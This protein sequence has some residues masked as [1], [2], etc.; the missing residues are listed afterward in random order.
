MTDSRGEYRYDATPVDT[1]L[2]RKTLDLGAQGPLPCPCPP[3]MRAIFCSPCVSQTGPCWRSSPTRWLAT[4]LAQPSALST[5]S[6][7]KGDLR[8]KLDKQQYAP[9]DTIKMRISTPYAGAGL[10][11]IEREKRAGSGMVHGP[12]WRKRAGKSAFPDDFQ[13]RGYVNVS[14]ARSLDS[15]VVYMK[16]HV[17]AVAPFMAGIDQRDL[18]LALTTPARALPG[19][20]V[21]VRLTSR[22]PGRALIFAVDEGVLQLTGFTTARPAARPFGATGRW[23]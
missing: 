1:E 13:G 7:A 14:Y 22:M 2:A 3:R 19:D 4:G 17:V 18:G 23:M 8:L 9:G 15:D 6:L 5:E 12:S 21:T 20:T 10:I 16:P 11:T